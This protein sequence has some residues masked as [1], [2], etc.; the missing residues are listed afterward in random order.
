[1]RKSVAVF[2]VLVVVLISRLVLEFR[3][4]IQMVGVRRQM[5]HSKPIQRLDIQ[6]IAQ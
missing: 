4:S 6:S 1:M 3:T 2:L 5:S